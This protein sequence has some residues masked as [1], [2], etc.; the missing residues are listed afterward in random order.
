[1]KKIL[2]FSSFLTFISLKMKG[3]ERM[4][5]DNRKISLNVFQNTCCYTFLFYYFCR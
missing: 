4:Q 5:K 3:D 2:F 1:M